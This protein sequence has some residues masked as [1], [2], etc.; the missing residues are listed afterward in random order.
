MSATA[1]AGFSNRR[2][3]PPTN[4]SRLDNPGVIAPPPILYGIAFAVGNLLQWVVPVR[5]LPANIATCMGLALLASGAALATWSRRT[6]Q[7]AGTNV[8]PALPATALVMAGPFRFSRNPMYLARTLLYLGLGCLLNALWVLA[9]LAPLL[10]I[11]H[12]G[13][14][15]REERYLGAKFGEAYLRYQADVRRWV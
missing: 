12:Y 2:T 8:H 11:M 6:M 10:L 13:V 3:L 4:A 7:G 5:I 1:Q 9:L 14:I 15:E